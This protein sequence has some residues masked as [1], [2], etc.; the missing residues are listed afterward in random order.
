MFTPSAAMHG[1]ERRVAYGVHL[2]IPCAFGVASENASNPNGVSMRWD[3]AGF[4]VSVE[5]RG[6]GGTVRGGDF[7]TL[8]VRAP[9]RIGVVIGDTCGRGAEGQA[10]LARILPT[11]LELAVSGVSPAS[12]LAALNYTVAAELPADSFVTAAAFEFDAEA[13]AF[14][15]ANAAHVPAIVR[16]A[17]GRPVSVVGRPSGAPP[18]IARSTTSPD[19][20]H[21]LIRGDGIV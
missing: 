1:S 21:E 17:H 11:V 15:V 2:I 9:G 3:R 8:E 10:Q 14:T 6:A 7:Y 5:C 18:A 13:G 20:R 19:Q 16:R 12:L 4:D